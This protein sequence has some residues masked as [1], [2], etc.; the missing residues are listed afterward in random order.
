MSWTDLGTWNGFQLWGDRYLGVVRISHPDLANRTREEKQ[1]AFGAARYELNSIG[2]LSKCQLIDENTD[3]RN[4]MSPA[5]RYE[6][7][8]LTNA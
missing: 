7:Y 4:L 2:L 6:L 5:A 1:A 3:L 8:G